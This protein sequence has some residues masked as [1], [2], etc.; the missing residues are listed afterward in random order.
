MVAYIY[1]NRFMET[2]LGMLLLYKRFT[3]RLRA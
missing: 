3:F 1:I 2:Q